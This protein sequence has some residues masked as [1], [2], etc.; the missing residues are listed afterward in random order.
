VNQNE[1]AL[2]IIAANFAVLSLIAIGGINPILPELHRQA[3]DVHGWMSSQRFTDLF[4][5]A[6]GA[7][8]PN[9]LVVTLIGWSVAGIPGAV[10]ATLAICGPSSVLA[11]LVSHLWHRFRQARWRIAIQ[12]GLVPIT[13]GLVAAGAYVIARTADTSF[14]AFAITILTAVVVYFTRVHPL[15]LLAAAAGLGL[16]GLV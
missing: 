9:I 12:S 6:Q 3:V 15:L 13:I 2:W 8:G 14:V 5:I 16:A 7:P 4:A 11:Y 10:V 1:G